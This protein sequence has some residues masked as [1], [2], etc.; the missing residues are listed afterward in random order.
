MIQPYKV[1]LP[2][3]SEAILRQHKQK[4][5]CVTVQRIKSLCDNAPSSLKSFS[6]FSF[7]SVVRLLIHFHNLIEYRKGKYQYCQHPHR[8]I[9]PF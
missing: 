7:P 9:P 4:K 8:L 5:E 3:P 1:G 2:T 6:S